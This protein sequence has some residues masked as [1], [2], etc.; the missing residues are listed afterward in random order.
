MI[1]VALATHPKNNCQCRCILSLLQEDQRKDIFQLAHFLRY[2]AGQ[3]VFQQGEPASNMYVCCSGQLKIVGRLEDGHKRVLR[4]VR[5]GECFGEEVLG[6]DRIHKV[7]AEAMVPTMVCLL[8]KHALLRILQSNPQVYIRLTEQLIDQLHQLQ[9]SIMLTNFASSKDR[10][11]H[12]L[13]F[14]CQKYGNET[15]H[16]IEIDLVLKEKDLAEL[17]GVPLETV[18]RYLSPY[19]KKGWFLC[20]ER[21]WFISNDLVYNLLQR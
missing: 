14:L 6:S 21:R 3:T 17:A 18:S 8:P 11:T 2:Q 12:A 15:E 16:G 20:K 9:E 13:R 7:F 19:K 5:F 4:L 10:V 1:N